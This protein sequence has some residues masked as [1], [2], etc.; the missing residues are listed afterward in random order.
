MCEH[1]FALSRLK[2]SA[3]FHRD[4]IDYKA[5]ENFMQILG[6]EQDLLT[7]LICSG[8]G[9]DGALIECI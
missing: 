1:A 9:G 6:L 4:Q 3:N 2:F 8:S 7:F 5:L